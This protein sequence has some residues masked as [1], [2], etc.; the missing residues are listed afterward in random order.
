MKYFISNTLTIFLL[1][2]LYQS[3]YAQF[4]RVNTTEIIH[5][6]GSA[7]DIFGT[8]IAVHKN[9]MAIGAPGMDFK[10]KK[11][12]GVVLLY[13]KVQGVWKLI[14]H[15]IP[16]DSEARAGFGMGLDLQHGRLLV[17][18]PKATVGA[19]RSAGKVYIFNIVKDKAIEEIQVPSP[20]PKSNAKYGQSVSWSYGYNISD[21][22][23]FAVGART[24]N[25]H[26]HFAHGN[27]Y[28]FSYNF[29][30]GNL[31]NTTFDI[32]EYHAQAHVGTVV[33]FGPGGVLIGIPNYT[34]AELSHEGA[35]LVKSIF[36]STTTLTERLLTASDARANDELGSSLGSD[37]NHIYVGAPRKTV[38]QNENLGVV[39]NF[40]VMSNGAIVEKE[41][42]IDSEGQSGD[43]F[44]VSIAGDKYDLVIASA[45]TSCKAQKKYG[46]IHT[47][48]VNPSPLIKTK[49]NSYKKYHCE[50]SQDKNSFGNE[51]LITADE[52]I[53]ASMTED[54]NGK[55]S[56]GK[57]YIV[58]RK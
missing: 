17:G 35:V 6:K 54:V 19:V 40:G 10:G 12:C 22:N 53:A 25:L 3:S 56:Q 15:I 11:D 49:P 4:S 8:R 42:I 18:A 24:E 44:G 14:Q 47:Y 20:N 27:V 43:Q 55:R 9:Y 5:S 37:T 16:S 39:Y 57:V 50:I 30:S 26:G 13:K 1:F 48:K 52:F 29:V 7:D 21:S 23:F 32:P 2:V 28:I 51:L 33:K 45:N 36:G 46:A 38:G 34:T 41:I 31:N 58:E